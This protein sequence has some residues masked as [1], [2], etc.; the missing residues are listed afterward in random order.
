[1]PHHRNVHL[2][3]PPE[4]CIWSRRNLDLWPLTLKIFQQ[5]PLTW[6]ITEIHPLRKEISHYAKYVLTDVRPAGW[7]ESIM[8]PLPTVSGGR[9][10]HCDMRLHLFQLPF[11]WVCVGL[12]KSVCL[13]RQ[14]ARPT[15]W[16]DLV[17]AAHNIHTYTVRIHL[18]QLFA[19]FAI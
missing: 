19:Y 3:P 4:K 18:P 8:P 14:T 15:S 5:C 1:M 10:Q 17:T 6:I 7:P 16:F 9:I 13:W 2:W 12:L 11:Q